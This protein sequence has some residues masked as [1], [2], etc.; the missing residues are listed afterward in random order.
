[1][2]RSP[3]KTSKK[4]QKKNK[5][6]KNPLIKTIMMDRNRF[7]PFTVAIGRGV[8]LT[9]FFVTAALLNHL[10]KNGNSSKN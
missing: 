6:E 2:K 8:E 4:K 3:K 1:M 7:A 10:A 9:G 5:S